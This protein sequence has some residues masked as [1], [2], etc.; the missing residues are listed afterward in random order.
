MLI[1]KLLRLPLY[2][3]LFLILSENLN[4]QNPESYNK[5]YN[6]T[7][8]ETSQ[9]NF[10]KALLVADS[11]Y[12]N[13][14]TPKFK[15]KSLMLSATLLQQYGDD[16]KSLEYALTAEQYVANSEDYVLQSKIYGFLSSQYRSLGLFS[17][18]KNYIIKSEYAIKKIDNILITNNLLAFVM[19]EKAYYEI[20]FKNYKKALN[21][22]YK[23]DSLFNAS[24]NKKLFLI[25]NNRQVEGLCYDRLGNYNKSLTCYRAAESILELMPDNYLKGLVFSGI[26]QVYIETKNLKKAKLYFKRAESIAEKSNHLSLKNEI[27]DTSQKYYFATKNIEK[28]AEVKIKQDSTREKISHNILAFID[29]QYNESQQKN[30]ADEKKSTT[31]T[32]LLIL[33]IVLFVI[34]TIVR[35][36][37]NRKQKAHVKNLEQNFYQAQEKHREYINLKES[38]QKNNDNTEVIPVLEYDQFSMMTPAT[39]KKLLAKLEKFENSILFTRNSI[40]LPY[41]ATYCDTNTKYLSYIINNFKHK[42]FNNYINELRINYIIGKLKSDS[43]YQKYKIASL[44]AEAGFSS[45][46]KF[47]TAFKKITNTSPSHY[48]QTL[49]DKKN[50]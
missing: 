21:F 19:L 41:L 7:Y 37:D 11:L 34:S 29:K 4:A 47:A 25:A 16:K 17:R 10:K 38:I 33:L 31:N 6:R 44:A 40:S 3:V 8:L 15:A 5:I 50:D 23:S 24:G 46:S 28:L 12:I 22:I 45:Q 36:L 14:E 35:F 32:L 13:S 30:T 42:D 20:K 1:K 18:S 43:K 39:E 49:K 48:L 26:A 27:Y 2:F 9:K